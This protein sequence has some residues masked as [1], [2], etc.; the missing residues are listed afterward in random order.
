MLVVD[1][2]KCTGCGLCS[3]LCPVSAITNKEDG[4]AEVD[5]S[6]CMECYACM[7]SCPQEAISEIE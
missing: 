2:E 5:P 4:K 3:T 6:Q 1:K 7:N